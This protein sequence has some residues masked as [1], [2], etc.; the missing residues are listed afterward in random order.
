MAEARIA[1]GHALIRHGPDWAR[2]SGEVL[3]QLVQGRLVSPVLALQTARNLAAAG[4]LL[5]A[6]RV[7]SE[8]ICDVEV[9]DGHRYKVATVLLMVDLACGPNTLADL[10]HMTSDRSLSEHTRNWATYAA[11]CIRGGVR[12]PDGPPPGSWLHS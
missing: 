2:I 12:A 7:L 1:V 5:E 9:P 3:H 8:L 11:D 6:R 10:H 4:G